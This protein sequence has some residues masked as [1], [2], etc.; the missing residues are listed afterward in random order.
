MAAQVAS[1][2]ASAFERYRNLL[3]SCTSNMVALSLRLQV[4]MTGLLTLKVYPRETV[5]FMCKKCR[6]MGQY[7]N[8]HLIWRYGPDITQPDLRLKVTN[9]EYDD[10][11]DKTCGAQFVG[12][13]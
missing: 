7:S 4:R 12:I 9:C 1:R 10:R 11:T 5:R 3:L 6:R 8:Q 13:A 2:R